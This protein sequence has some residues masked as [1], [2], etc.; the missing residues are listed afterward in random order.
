M[1]YWR[2]PLFWRLQ[3]ALFGL[4]I[5]VHPVSMRVMNDVNDNAISFWDKLFFLAF[6]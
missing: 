3:L 5:D 6:N 1:S 4:G 2:A